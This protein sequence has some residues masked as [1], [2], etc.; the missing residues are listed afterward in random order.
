MSEC[1]HA[2]QEHRTWYWV[3]DGDPIPVPRSALH[4]NHADAMAFAESG[5][6]QNNPALRWIKT[7][8]E[9]NEQYVCFRWDAPPLPPK[10]E[11]GPVPAARPGLLRRLLGASV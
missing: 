10:P 8:R 7:F 3:E 1:P 6:A 5:I 11:P 9:Y 4:D 2:D